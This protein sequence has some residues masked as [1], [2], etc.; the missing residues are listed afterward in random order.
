MFQAFFVSLFFDLP[1]PR[2]FCPV[3]RYEHPVTGQRIKSSMRVFID[4]KIH[5][6][7]PLIKKPRSKTKAKLYR[8]AF[9]FS[10]SNLNK[11]LIRFKF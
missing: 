11:Q 8:V 10:V 9:P 6:S 1:L 5:A 2:P 4:I 3:R 7:T